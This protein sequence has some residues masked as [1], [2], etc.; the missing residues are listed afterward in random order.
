MTSWRLSA[1][2]LPEGDT[3]EDWWM[4]TRVCTEAAHPI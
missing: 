4:T 2:V 1:V 3:A